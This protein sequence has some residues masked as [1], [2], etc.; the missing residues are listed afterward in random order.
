MGSVSID[1]AAGELTVEFERVAGAIA[2]LFARPGARHHASGYLKGLLSDIPRKNSWQLAEFL[3]DDNPGGLQNLL[4]QASWSADAL[5]DHLG[6]Y[7]R[8]T[9]GDSEAVLILDETGFLKKGTH[10]AGV[11]RQYSGTAGRIENSQVGVFL[12]YRS[13]TGCALIDRELYLPK[14]WTDDRDRCQAAGVPDDRTFLTKVQLAEV[15]LRR[16]MAANL[17]FSWVTG[18]AVY[19]SFSLRRLLEEGEKNYVIA[20]NRSLKLWAGFSQRKAEAIADDLPA[21]RWRTISAGDGSKGRRLSR[22]A[23]LEINH[24]LGPK[25]KRWL[26]VRESLS[27]KRDRSFYVASGPSRTTLTKLA[28]IAGSR[29][30]IEVAFEESKGQTG[31]DEYEVRSF[32]GWQRH[33]T[34][35]MLAHALL[36]VLRSRTGDDRPE[37]KGGI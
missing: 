35:S 28:E 33:I 2:P 27:E 36:V 16:A 30:S 8:E 19:A 15:M 10:S 7:V 9:L 32:E 23:R 34:F 29:W 26:L 5:R 17:P 22:W 25:R 3:G 4:N 31:L 18:D 13:A 14:E 6:E 37:E 1:V 21:S 11:A 20:C 12:A 24:D